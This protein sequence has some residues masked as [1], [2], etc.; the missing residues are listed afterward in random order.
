MEGNELQGQ[1]EAFPSLILL[2][3]AELLPCFFPP[4][5]FCQFSLDPNTAATDLLLFDNNKQAKEVKE[6]QPYPD[7]P[8]R[9]SSWT[10][11]LCTEGLTGRR[12]WEVR[13][14]GRINMGVTYRGIE[15]RGNSDD[16]CIGRNDQSWGLSCSAEGYTA[17]HNN[18]PIEI[19]QRSSC[20]SNWVGVYLDWTAGTVSFY[21]FPSAVSCRNRI[22][23][24]TFHSTFTKPLYPAFGFGRVH[25]FGTDSELLPC[26]LYLS[27]IGE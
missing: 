7:H 10:Q 23:L 18:R 14:N 26:S 13:W 19:T 27:Q 15:R 8:E 1:R 5:D 12:Y 20:G 4:P 17:W 21:C 11:V 6:K 9:F 16:C 24:Y 2:N 22:H 25:A 3:V